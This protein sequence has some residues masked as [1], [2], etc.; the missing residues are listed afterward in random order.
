[1]DGRPAPQFV[2]VPPTPTRLPS[3]IVKVIDATRLCY[4]STIS[5]HHAGPH[6]SAMNVSLQ[7]D[8]LLGDVL[9]MTTRRDT[10]KYEAIL[11]NANVAVLLHDFDGLRTSEIPSPEVHARGS[12]AVTVYGKA[13]LQDGEAAA[14]MRQ[15]HLLRNSGS[16]HFI[17]DESTYA[18]FA[19]VPE[20]M[21]CCDVYDKV[22]TWQADTK[23]PARESPCC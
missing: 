21:L 4:L 15:A 11:T 17:A 2:D 3:H 14:R 1:M 10:Q 20:S 6:L 12:L 5:V 23:H 18:V 9:V 13:V 22:F 16:A 8:P 19:V 7:F